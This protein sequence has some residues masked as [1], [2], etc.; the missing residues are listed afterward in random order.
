MRKPKLARTLASRSRLE[1]CS[2]HQVFDLALGRNSNQ[3]DEQA[4]ENCGQ[5]NTPMSKVHQLL[6]GRPICVLKAASLVLEKPNVKLRGS[7]LSGCPSRMTGW[8]ADS[9]PTGLP[10]LIELCVTAVLQP[11]HVVRT[12]Y[13][14]DGFRTGVFVECCHADND[15][16]LR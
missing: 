8:A 9:L 4:N 1:R 2:A 6:Q 16:G 7:P 3:Y 11:R 5:P 13:V 10:L 12:P 14:H 15:V